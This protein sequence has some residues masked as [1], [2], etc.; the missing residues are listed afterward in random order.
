MR[1]KDEQ[2]HL[3]MKIPTKVKDQSCASVRDTSELL[4]RNLNCN[5]SERP[6]TGNRHKGSFKMPKYSFST[7]LSKGE[8]SERVQSK[9]VQSV[10]MQVNN[11]YH[12][13]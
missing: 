9:L 13:S 3:H 12:P 5:Y 10:R 7:H 2:Q 6:L 11:Y 4:Q 1:N 8:A